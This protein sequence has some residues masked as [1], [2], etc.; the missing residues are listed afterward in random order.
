M[1]AKRCASLTILAVAGCTFLVSAAWAQTCPLAPWM[2]FRGTHLW[3]STDGQIY[4][5]KADRVSIDA[6]GTPR[7]YCPGDT[8]LD[9]LKNAGLPG[10]NWADV[11]IADPANPN[12]P[13]V[14]TTGPGKGCYL[15]GTSLRSKTDTNAASY[16]DAMTVPYMVFPSGFLKLPGTGF[17]G[18]FAAMRSADGKHSAAAIVADTGGGPKSRLGEIS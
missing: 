10:P 9:Y 8:G 12:R 11:L 16:V 7:A 18:D 14:Q 2:T 5:Y 1:N 6:D 13:F 17:V 4:A 3:R 15:A